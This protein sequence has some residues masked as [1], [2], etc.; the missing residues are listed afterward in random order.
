MVV[1]VAGD[2]FVVQ[3]DPIKMQGINSKAPDGG[4]LRLSM[5]RLGLSVRRVWFSACVCNG[6]PAECRR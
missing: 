4:E 6:C 5:Y 2:A 3:P 1:S